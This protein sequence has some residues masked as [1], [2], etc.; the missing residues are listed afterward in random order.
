MSKIE[1]KDVSK[2]YGS[3]EAVAGLDLVIEQGKFVTFLG[4]SGSGKTTTMRM[5]AGL[6]KPSEGAISIGGKVVSGD[7]VFVPTFK[8]Q[9]GMVFQSYAVWPHKTVEENVV[10]PL[11]QRGFPRAQHRQRVH[12]ILERVGLAGHAQRYPSQ[13]SGGQQQR[14]SLAR[15]LVAEPAVVLFD[16]PLSNLDAKLR[17]SMRDLL[18]EMHRQFGTTSVYVTHDQ[19]E[20]MVLS[21]TV[22]I[23]N[24]GR[25]VQSGSPEDL[26]ERPASRF[27]ADFIGAA[28]TLE[29]DS[30]DVTAAHVTLRNGQRLHVAAGCANAREKVLII[31]PHQIAIV[32]EG[33]GSGEGADTGLDAGPRHNILSGSVRASSYL[34]DRC[35]YQVDIGA[36]MSLAVEVGQGP[37]R[38]RPGEAIH[39]QLPRN[40][41]VVI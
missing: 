25:L 32:G 6:E 20:A 35:R 5:I 9:L 28:N 1:L 2:R 39:M 31:R 26:Y 22:H 38:L 37:A 12:N 13:L 16:E 8:R 34:G 7:G 24:H 29:V 36:G 10:F 23:M 11:Q 19:E 17:D 14:V 41:C 30:F 15:A 27:V 4:P 40:A 3:V 21:D 18:A 33:A